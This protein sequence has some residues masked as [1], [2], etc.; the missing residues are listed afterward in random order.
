L[1]HRCGPAPRPPAARSRRRPVRLLVVVALALAGCTGGG[2][3]PS[4]SADRA[5]GGGAAPRGR[6]GGTLA[7]ALLDPGPLDPAR[8]D[9]L[10]DEIVLGNLFDGLTAL[11]PSGA[12]RPAVAA[13]WTA[14]PTLRRW[15]FRLRPEARWSNGAR[16][17]AADFVF[18]WHRLAGPKATPGPSPARTLLSAVTGYRAY[19]TGKARSIS[20]LDAPDPASLR[21]VLD[22]P[23]ADLPAVVATLPLSPLPEAEAAEDPAAYLARP[24]GNGPFRLATPARPLTLERNPA[25]WSSP[26][27]L[28]R[29]RVHTVPD[30]QTAWLELQHGRVAFAP[31]PPDQLAA[32][33]T[34][35]GPSPDGRTRPGLLQAPTLTTWQLAFNLKSRPAR[36]PRW[37]QAVSLAINRQRLATTVAAT[38]AAR[39]VP[40]GVEPAGVAAS[41]GSGAAPS[42][43]AC[44]HDPARARSLFAK[45]KGG[46][47]PI[48]LTVPSGSQERRI[49]GLIADDLADAGVELTLASR[50]TPQTQA[51]LV[52]QIARYP[53][54]D[55]SLTAQFATRG[56]ANLTGYSS[57]SVDRLLDQARATLDDPTRTT[58]YR[59]AEAAILADLPVAP[60]LTANRAA[61]L[62]PGIQGF[63]LLP[64]GTLDLAAVSLSG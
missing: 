50:P 20:G 11:D 38:P 61:V 8:A 7:I 19:T 62:S 12:V 35:H 21:V 2:S 24:I 46:S 48:T 4:G 45:A 60:L 39:L 3:G 6:V 36:D 63:D 5:P 37:R 51:T 47:V 57:P 43:P 33:R 29:V 14:D 55:A 59:Q 9:G 31:V 26:A 53:R 40:P 49:A 32:A 25:Y 16:V 54:P 58:R 18:A 64:W 44:T 13:S 23:F 30:Q 41:G 10:E 27:L 56:T 52:R 22:R 15:A 34:V 28:D 17:S 1:P 42:C